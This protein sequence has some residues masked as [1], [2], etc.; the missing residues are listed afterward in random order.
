[1]KRASRG[2]PSTFGTAHLTGHWNSS[3]QYKRI[4]SKGCIRP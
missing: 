4:K 3:T 1:L 2:D